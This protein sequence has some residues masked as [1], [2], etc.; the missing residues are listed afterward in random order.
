MFFIKNWV[1]KNPYTYMY[2]F[3]E[4]G[5]VCVYSFSNTD[6]TDIKEKIKPD[7]GLIILGKHA[8]QDPVKLFEITASLIKSH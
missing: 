2:G 8:S 3:L 5:Y 6:D 7:T 1:I 4:S